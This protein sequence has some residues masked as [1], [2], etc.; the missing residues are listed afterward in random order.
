MNNNNKASLF[1]Q[2]ITPEILNPA[3]YTNWDGIKAKVK[4]IRREIALL[5]SLDK[6]NPVDDLTDLL[7]N[8]SRVLKVL[9][10]LIAHTPERIFFDEKDKYIDFKSDLE[11]VANDTERAKAIAEIFVEMG[12]VEFLKEV[13]SVE[14]VV[15]GILLGLEPNTRKNRR[16]AKLEA[17]INNIIS[18]TIE[19]INKE[20]GLNLSFEPQ[21]YVDLANERKKIDYVILQDGKQKIAIE[22]NF[23]ST[24]G[25]KPSE[26]L[27]RAYPEVQENLKKKGLGFIVITD[28]I[29]WES[30]KPV[31]S[32]AYEKL[33]YLMN[34][35]QAKSGELEKAILELLEGL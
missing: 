18:S 15:K 1:F 5:Q 6:D 19:N 32:T 14:D 17:A 13:R 28:G 22:V 9:Q 21:M 34:I 33:D 26:V 2:T 29:G 20:K 10:L 25:S 23:Y 8:N 35:K 3:D 16:G 27:G 12:L 11:N 30:M 7:H 24:S 4:A 31:I